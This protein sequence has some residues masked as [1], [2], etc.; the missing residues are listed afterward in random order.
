MLPNLSRRGMRSLERK[1]V[2]TVEHTAAMQRMSRNAFHGWC[3]RLNCKADDKAVAYSAIRA[4]T[5]VCERS[6]S[7]GGEFSADVARSRPRLTADSRRHSSPL[8]PAV[9]A[10]HHSVTR[11]CDVRHAGHVTLVAPSHRY[12][13]GNQHSRSEDLVRRRRPRTCR[14]LARRLGWRRRSRRRRQSAQLQ[15]ASAPLSHG[16]SSC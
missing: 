1:E 12:E 16:Q 4:A 14:A 3:V 11:A 2:E 9:G 8:F 15:R 5:Q 13:P 10:E 7:A 6:T